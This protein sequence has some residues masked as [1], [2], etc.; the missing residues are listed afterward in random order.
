MT[1]FRARTPAVGQ[2]P[3]KPQTAYQRHKE[4]SRAR[5]RKQAASDREISTD[6]PALT[7]ADL[8][9]KAKCLKDL[10][11]ALKTLFPARFAMEFGPD[12]LEL[13]TDLQ[14]A[15]EQGEQAVRAM[16]RGTG[17]TSI[18]VAACIWAILL[19]LHSMV[20]VIAATSEAAKELLEQIESNA[21]TNDELY[22][23]FP[24][25]FHPI[26][27][28]EGIKQRRLLW[29]GK[30]ILQV[31]KKTHIVFPSLPK[32][33]SAS[34]VIKGV[35]ILGRVRGM[36][37]PHPD[38]R[39]LRP[40]LVLLDDIQTKQ[41]AL[42][43]G[44]V[45]KR[46]GVVAADV[47]GLA[48]PGKKLSAL[49]AVT[50]IVTGDAADQLLDN[51]KF[52]QWHGKRRPLLYGE[53]K[54]PELWSEYDELRREGLRLDVGIS[55]ATAFYKKNRKAMDAGMKAA[56]PARFNPDELSGIQYAQNLKL[57]DE[58]VF[59]CEY[60][61]SPLVEESSSAQTD[62]NDIIT[63]T[64]N[65]KR[66][67]LPLETEYLAAGLDCQGHYLVR[68]I[69]G[70]ALDGTPHVPDYGT[71]PKQNQANFT[72]RTASPTIQDRFPKLSPDEQLYSALTHA[73]AE[74]M[75]MKFTRADGL[76][77]RLRKI[78]VDA[79][80]LSHVVKRFCRQSEHRD[81][82]LPCMGLATKLGSHINDKPPATGEIS[83]D[84]F[85]L[86][87]L[88][89]G[90]IARV[91]AF[92]S[93]DFVSG[94][95]ESLQKPIGSPG[96]MTIFDAPAYQHRCWAEQVCSQYSL[97]AEAKGR[98]HKLWQLKPGKPDDDFLDATKLARL[99]AFVLGLIP[100]YQKP[101]PKASPGMKREPK[102]SVI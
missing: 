26:R 52:P 97:E 46:L 96:A 91:C 101:K 8:K 79:R 14:R 86:P 99:G 59:A 84:G 90:Q 29:Q 20:A 23:Y 21:F 71:W 87:P 3:E 38:G 51:E 36:N 49:C 40:T 70:Y 60:Q 53:P 1:L 74:L 18:M 37:Q 6:F 33:P 54:H 45:T 30:P 39:V 93:N 41:S 17:K 56:W 94:V 92:E 42:K 63:R 44:Q 76:E 80:W 88:K 100:S 57:T 95:H 9:V 34:A 67:Q 11:F 10:A 5:Q 58:V 55:K 24:E 2:S 102:C 35:G 61:N 25:V 82:L 47:L 81:I 15:I 27:K 7:A 28:L 98:R 12:Q 43:E 62:P 66:F 89:A 48:P 64:I 69:S 32:S 72:R 50:V 78:C 16:P 13:I 75:A 77:M 31:W 4:R 22:R 83:R 73:V 68:T 85:R 19:G 65:L